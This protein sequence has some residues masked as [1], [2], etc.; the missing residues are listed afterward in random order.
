MIKKISLLLIILLIFPI[1][2]LAS[3][4]TG[5]KI[6]NIYY[7]NLNDAIEAVDDN[8]TI[9]L[10]S[11]APLDKGIVL[12][13]NITID[14]NGNTISSPTAVFEVQK[15]ALTITGKGI[16]KETEPN[17]GV[18]RVIGSETETDEKHSVVKIGKDVTLEGWAGIFVSHNN[19][20]SYGVKVYVEGNINAVS[21][22]SDGVGIG[23]Y[24]NGSIQDKNNE[25]EINIMDGTKINSNGVGIYVG[26]YS[27]VSIK[28]AEITGV[29]NGIGIKAGA[30]EIDGANIT[31]TG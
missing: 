20:K 1:S 13:K 21:D 25:P 22:T 19:K 9:K 2:T 6:G 4:T 31:C 8:Q 18:I 28:K 17:Y 29:E 24:I 16:I 27:N 7:D 30:I 26:G 11:N 5:A 23:V 3:N 12:T 14:L 10:L 15:G